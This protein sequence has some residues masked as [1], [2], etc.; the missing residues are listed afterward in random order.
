MNPL[1]G[2]NRFVDRR[3]SP[4]AK[5]LILSFLAVHLALGLARVAWSPWTFQAVVD[6]LALNRDFTLPVF[7]VWQIGTYAFVH[8]D[9]LHLAFDLAILWSFAPDVER[10]WGRSRFTRWFL[11]SSIAGGLLHQVVALGTPFGHAPAVGAT[12]P[13][14]GLVFA[15]AA[16][17]PQRRVHLFFAMWVPARIVAWGAM[18]FALVVLR[19]GGWRDEAARLSLSAHLAGAGAAFFYLTG[20]HR[21]WDFREWRYLR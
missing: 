5:L 8:V 10:R 19:S 4:G 12:G 1:A 7:F 2:I 6:Q 15:Y 3:V 11:F 21:T 14:L 20:Y 17:Y 16:Y 9:P 13:L 18:A